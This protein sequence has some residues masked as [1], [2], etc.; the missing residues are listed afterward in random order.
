MNTGNPYEAVLADLRA[1][2]DEIDNAISTIEK[3][4]R[5]TQEYYEFM[6]IINKKVL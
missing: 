3:L 6:K 1:K 2:R 4:G 5:L